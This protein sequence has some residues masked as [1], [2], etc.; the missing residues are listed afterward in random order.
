[1]SRKLWLSIAAFIAFE[2]WISA[3][4][5]AA[6]KLTLGVI[7]TFLT[8]LTLR[9]AGNLYFERLDKQQVERE[10]QSLRG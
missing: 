8:L 6:G 1:M 10:N 4:F 9:A 2:I 7:S 5:L 3:G